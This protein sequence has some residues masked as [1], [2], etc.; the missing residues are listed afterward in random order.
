[1]SHNSYRPAGPVAEVSNNGNDLAFHVATILQWGT[2]LSPISQLPTELLVFIFQSTLVRVDFMSNNQPTEALRRTQM[3]YTM[4]Q[5]SK[6]WQGLID[7]TPS[8][9]IFILSTLPP[10]VINATLNRS[11]NL[12]LSIIYDDPMQPNIHGY[13]SPEEFLRTIAHTRS[14]WF[15]IALETKNNKCLPGYLATPSRLLQ[16]VVVRGSWNEEDTETLELLGGQTDNLHHLRIN[17][18]SI[19][20][21]LGPLNQ[22]KTLELIAER[23]NLA[24]SD[25]VDLLRAIPLLQQLNINGLFE[26][27]AH[28]NSSP[29]ITLPHLKVL[30][31]SSEDVNALDY[32]LQHIRTPS[33][34]NFSVGVQDHEDEL[35]LSRFLNETL[36]PF[37]EILR[38]VHVENGASRLVLNPDEFEWS[39][40]PGK[41][42][43]Y[44]FGVHITRFYPIAVHWVGQILR[45][46]PGLEVQ[47]STGIVLSDTVLRNLAPLQCATSVSIV[48]QEG[49]SIRKLLRLLRQPSGPNAALPSL[50]RLRKLLLPPSGWSVQE[51]LNMVQGRCSMFPKAILDHPPLVVHIERRTWLKNITAPIFLDLATLTK[52]KEALGIEGIRFVG[53]HDK[54]DVL[55]VTWNETASRPAWG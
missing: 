31:L 17:G 6:R 37:H 9:W 25:I 35:D 32:I 3:I 7:G 10:H 46:E 48:A 5:V 30:E 42:K 23:L 54:D 49:E 12:P 51:L 39:S 28:H 19:L 47:L 4:R 29:I 34:I 24:A 14:R 40:F 43:G 1:M 22:L 16:T 36:Q 11:A 13:P 27:P 2:P 45:E 15:A 8:F 41:G 20:W 21:K 50:P 52:I 26:P 33:C 55:A 38:R 18:G 44:Y 53:P